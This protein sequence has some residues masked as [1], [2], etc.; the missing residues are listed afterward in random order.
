MAFRPCLPSTA[1]L[2][3]VAVFWAAF[4][5]LG[6]AQ[7]PG[8]AEAEP[9]VTDKTESMIF[10]REDGTL[11]VRL[12]EKIIGFSDP[13]MNEES[14]TF[15]PDGTRLAYFI[16][17]GDGLAVVVD[18]QQGEIFE[19]IAER[20]LVF[21]PDGKRFGYV[22]TRPG[23]Q[24]AV[25]DGKAHEYRGVSQRG[26]VFS[27]EGGRVGWVA[28]R[29]GKQLAVID[30]VESSPYDGVAPQ[31]II[32]SPDGKRS[33]YLATTGGKSLV[34]IDGEDGE[35]FD[36]AAGLKFTPGGK[37]LTYMAVREGK[38]YAVVDTNAYGPFDDLR[39]VT[40]PS[41]QN[42][43]PDVFEV[44]REGSSVGF[45]AKRGEDWFAFVNGKEYG[46]HKGCAGLALSPE[47]SRV[48][49]L[50]TRG[51]GWFMVVDGVEQ[52]YSYLKTLSFSPDGQRLASIQKKA[53]KQVALVD[54]VAGK[55]YDRIEEPGIR[56]S[57][58]GKHLAYVADEKGA[59]LV[60]VDGVEGARFERLGKTP[61]SFIPGS[62]RTIYSIRRGKRESLVVDGVEGPALKS[63]RSLAFAP[64]GS[65]YAYA[66]ELDDDK[67][68]VVVDGESYGPGGKLAPGETRAFHA[69][70]RRTPVVSPDGKRVA[71]TGSRGNSWVAVV[72]GVEGQP[73]GLMQ[74]GTL[75]FSPDGKHVAYIASREGKK[76]LVLDGLEI[77]NNYDGFQR[78]SDFVW[79]SPQRFSIRA[80]RNP[81]FLLVEVEIL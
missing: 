71:W 47:G 10:E 16:M 2:F 70:G 43:M 27:E 23:S 17:A 66:G 8:A 37:H 41:P 38:R 24:F 21:S 64:D 51:E 76:Y 40:E 25:V 7:A 56:F 42:P 78:D 4:P 72:D 32:F 30:G 69:L 19:G 22:G 6:A 65:R 12:T 34:V 45:V 46:P 44:S 29:D 14:L 67:W 1:F 26:I 55:E 3:R 52:P 5:V 28:D 62:A 31:G 15:S 53:D 79:S 73:Y 48:A 20:S 59:K 75:D 50:A 49:Y 68:I 63:Y 35:L 57:P 33:A 9:E 77:D 80:G 18:G 61:L 54:G 39:A 36:H 58:D 60:V 13:A 11:R 74:R 81:R